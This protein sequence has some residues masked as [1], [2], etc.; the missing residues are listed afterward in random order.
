MKEKETV[1]GGWLEQ[2][3]NRKLA[4]MLALALAILFSAAVFWF[5]GRPM[6]RFVSDPTLFRDWVGRSGAWGRLA[7][8]GMMALQ[9][10]IAFIPGEP[11][12]LGAG[13]AFGA[14]EGT[15]LC[16]LGAALGTA[17]VFL[18]VRQF[19]LRLVELFFS[20]EKLQS[21]PLLRDTRRL[22]LL[23]FIAFFI[24]GTPKDLL[25]YVLG[26]THM[27]FWPCLLLITV[28]RIP[29]VITSTLGGDALGTQQY[30]F[31]IAVFAATLLL[32]GIGLL[33]YRRMCRK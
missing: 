7:F 17:V 16:L 30:G 4:G 31:A 10:L 24:P 11:L 28:A 8:V 5:V 15:L 32:S 20:K 25:T 9:V 14:V 26:L 23:T 2:P 27:K 19:G 21:L 18:L 1:A 13:Y 6:L 33:V 12:E 29:S 3:R 22:Y